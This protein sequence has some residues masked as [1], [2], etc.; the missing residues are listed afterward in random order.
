M[1]DNKLY[2][3]IEDIYLSGERE[4]EFDSVFKSLRRKQALRK[5]TFWT[6]GIA[7]AAVILL[8]VVKPKVKKEAELT[9]IQIAESITHI[10]ELGIGDIESIS[11]KP[12]GSKALVTTQLK[13]GS[14]CCYIMTLDQKEQTITL[15]ANR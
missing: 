15:T 8:L 12:M 6:T 11:A 5:A 9:P 3:Q 2:R 14:T 13:D 4:K 1:D 7:A 10:M